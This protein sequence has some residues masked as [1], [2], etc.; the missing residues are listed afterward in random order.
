MTCGKRYEDVAGNER[1]CGDEGLVCEECFQAT[2]AEFAW[3]AHEPRVTREDVEG[4]YERGSPK[5]A[6]LLDMLDREGR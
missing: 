5:R 4:A 6:A 3:M 2:A 1:T